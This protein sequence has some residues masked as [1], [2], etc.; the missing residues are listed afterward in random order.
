MARLR[1]LSIVAHSGLQSF[2]TSLDH[3]NCTGYVNACAY[4]RS[5]VNGRVMG[6]DAEVKPVN[7]VKAGGAWYGP[8]QIKPSTKEDDHAQKLMDERRAAV[9]RAVRLMLLDAVA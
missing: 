9:A 8:V 4:A 1:L 6:S 5:L 2:R 3:W 7:L